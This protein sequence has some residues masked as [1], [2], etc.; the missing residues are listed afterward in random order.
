MEVGKLHFY[1]R[2]CENVC[3]LIFC[4]EKEHLNNL[5]INEISDEV[6]VSLDVFVALKLVDVKA[7]YREYWYQIGIFW[8][9][10]FCLSTMYPYSN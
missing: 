7:F 10:F 8:G 1:K 9:I 5:S 4:R 3:N 2:L 6:H